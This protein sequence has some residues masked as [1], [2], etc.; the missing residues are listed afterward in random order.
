[1]ADYYDYLQHKVKGSA[2]FQ[3]SDK[4]R[5]DFDGSFEMRNFTN[6]I[7]QD[8]AGVFL[9]GDEKR[10]DLT[11]SLDAEFGFVFWSSPSGAEAELIGQFWWDKSISNMEDEV[12][13][14]TNSD[15]FGGLLGVEL[16]LP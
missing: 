4:F 12:S 3:W 15:F 10:R 1:M 13:F 6:Y 9:S 11:F 14:D 16:R 5:T 8:S 2:D 7:A